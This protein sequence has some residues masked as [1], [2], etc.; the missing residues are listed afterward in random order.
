MG[1]INQIIA[2]IIEY[3]CEKLCYFLLLCMSSWEGRV[4]GREGNETKSKVRTNQKRK[5]G[6]ERANEGV[7]EGK[8]KEGERME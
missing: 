5:K 2:R 6:K 7:R 3:F 1:W 8:I 4:K